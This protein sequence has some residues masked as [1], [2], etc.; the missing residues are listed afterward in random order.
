MHCSCAIKV[1]SVLVRTWWVFAETVTYDELSY[2]V[3]GTHHVLQSFIKLVP[4]AT[5][6]PSVAVQAVKSILAV[7]RTYIRT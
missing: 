1:I 3:A 6:L 7:I 5:I 2:S 4:A